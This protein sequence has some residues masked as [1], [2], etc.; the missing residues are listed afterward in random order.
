MNRSDFKILSK[1][2]IPKVDKSIKDKIIKNTTFVKQEHI[3][4]DNSFILPSWL[5]AFSFVFVLATALSFYFYVSYNKP[6]YLNDANYQYL[7]FTEELENYYLPSE[8]E[9]DDQELYLISSLE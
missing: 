6:N 8:S 4:V 5:R 7:S 2:E 3:K 1:L 9:L